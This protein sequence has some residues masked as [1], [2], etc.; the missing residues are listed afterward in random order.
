MHRLLYVLERQPWNCA[1]FLDIQTTNAN[2][3]FC[4]DIAAEET[5]GKAEHSWKQATALLG[6]KLKSVASNMTKEEMVHMLAVYL[7]AGSMTKS[8]ETRILEE[9][10]EHGLKRLAEE[11]NST[12]QLIQELVLGRFQVGMVSWDCPTSSNIFCTIHEL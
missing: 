10:T 7:V 9:L 12:L 11:V 8:M 1:P 5:L 4:L 6:A 3:F 2:Q